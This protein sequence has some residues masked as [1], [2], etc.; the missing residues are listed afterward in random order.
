[1]QVLFAGE[2]AHRTFCLLWA[3]SD[4]F[5]E[6]GREM[7]INRFVTSQ[8]SKH[9]RWLNSGIIHVGEKIVKLAIFYTLYPIQLYAGLQRLNLLPLW[10]L[11]PNPFSKSFFRHTLPPMPLIWNGNSVLSWGIAAA[12]CPA[13]VFLGM[14]FFSASMLSKST[15]YALSTMPRPDYPDEASYRITR[16]EFFEGQERVLNRLRHQTS[17][18]A[19]IRKDIASLKR[20]LVDINLQFRNVWRKYVLGKRPSV[21]FPEDVDN[22]ASLDVYIIPEPVSGAQGSTGPVQ[23]PTPLALA[24]STTITPNSPLLTPTSSEEESDF[25]EANTS[26]VRIRARS[27][28]TSTL[29]MD[30]EFTTTDQIGGLVH[31]SSFASSPHPRSSIEMT[32]TGPARRKLVIYPYI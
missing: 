15:T 13:T 31:T 30:V 7:L 27:G 5:V 29:H 28:S 22:E 32:Q 4:I 14:Q 21:G 19:E 26:N 1:M 23:M 12:T 10:P 17:L 2:F 25:N 9:R 24:G 20:T 18:Q 8:Q 6:I 3:S 16:D 11:L